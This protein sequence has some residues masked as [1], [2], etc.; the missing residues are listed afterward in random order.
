MIKCLLCS[1]P[2]HSWQKCPLFGTTK[3]YLAAVAPAP[4]SPEELV[5][6]KA[7]SVPHTLFE[8]LY[9]HDED[10]LGELM[11]DEGL[12]P[13]ERIL[14]TELHRFS[15]KAFLPSVLFGRSAPSLSTTSSLRV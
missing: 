9:G 2:G 5:Q 7:D 6:A 14:A 8:D 11:E 4:Q 3:D 13:D 10:A 15:Q 12:S 1:T